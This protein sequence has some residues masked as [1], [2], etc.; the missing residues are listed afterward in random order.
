MLELTTGAM[1]LIS[2]IYGS[3]QTDN[4]AQM[5][6]ASSD[7][8]TVHIAL[9]SSSKKPT[10]MEEYLANEYADTPILVEVARCESEFRQFN[11]DG[12]VLRGRAVADDIGVMQIN[13]H[14][15]GST[16]KK[17]GIDIY[18]VEGNV[19][20]A[21]YLYT[22]SGTDPWSASKPCWSKPRPITK[23]SELAKK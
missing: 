13:E 19:A 3:G 5:I 7:P 10:N 20:Y 9:I 14:Y 4:H 2:S 11:K 8:E 18:T 6:T 23:S 22:K 15:H 1:F 21:K 16:A 12:S 17:M